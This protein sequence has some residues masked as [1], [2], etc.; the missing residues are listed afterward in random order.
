MTNPSKTVCSLVGAT[1]TGISAS[2]CGPFV[3]GQSAPHP[4]CLTRLDGPAQAGLNDFTATTDSLSFFDLDKRQAGAE[5][6]KDHK[7]SM[8]QD[9]EQKRPLELE[10]LLGAVLEIADLVG[11]ATPALRA[12][13]GSVRLLDPGSHRER[14]EVPGA[15][16][17]ARWDHPDRAAS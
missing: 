14:E 16:S 1:G 6:I 4:G 15:V 2:V 12:I 13:Y 10:P 11:V 3:L 7:T 8:L 5:R 17:S 9:V